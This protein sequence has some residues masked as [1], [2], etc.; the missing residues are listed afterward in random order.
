MGICPHTTAIPS[1]RTPP[2]AVK[3][4]L[5]L[6][7][8]LLFIEGLFI[9][10]ATTQGHLVKASHTYTHNH[11]HAHIHTH[12]HMHAHTHTKVLDVCIVRVCD[13]AY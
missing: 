9:T 10:L 1:G 13:T 2:P 12:A 4:L 3:A 11:I 8:L 6:L 7:L 5:L